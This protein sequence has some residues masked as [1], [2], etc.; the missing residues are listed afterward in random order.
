MAFNFSRPDAKTKNSINDLTLTGLSKLDMS[1]LARLFVTNKF[2]GVGDVAK[3]YNK[4]FVSERDFSQQLFVW[5]H[6]G[7]INNPL[8][9][10]CF[11]SKHVLTF[12]Y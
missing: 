1:S 10:Y 11:T 7:D 9:F 2:V 5:R 12:S 4:V 6:N 3:F 8:H